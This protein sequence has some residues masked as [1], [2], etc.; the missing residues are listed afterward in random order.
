MVKEFHE[1][2]LII[3]QNGDRFEIGKI[4]RLTDDGAFVWYSSGETAAK[5]SFS[6]MHLLKNANVITGTSLG[7]MIGNQR[8]I[9]VHAAMVYGCKDCGS[10][11][12]MY[13]EKGLEEAG[14]PDRKPV[15]FAITCP[16]CKGFH[17]YDISGCLKIP[18]EGYVELPKDASCFENLPDRD[19]GKPMISPYMKRLE[20]DEIPSARIFKDR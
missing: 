10:R 19:C 1:G 2:D 15:P 11:W 13:L 16:Y 4:K 3:Y 20:D 14:D 12:L 17:A 5:T 6:D 9:M 18:E 7:G 8:K